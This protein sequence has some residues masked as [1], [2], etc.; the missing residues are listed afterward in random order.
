MTEGPEIPAG[1]VP[2]GDFASQHGIDEDAVVAGIKDGDYVGRVVDG[3]WYVAAE[4]APVPQVGGAHV[5]H[6]YADQEG[7]DGVI[8]C[9]ALHDLSDQVTALQKAASLV[10]SK[11]KLVVAHP[12]GAS[13]VLRQSAANPVLVKRGLPTADELRKFPLPHGIA[14]DACESGKQRNLRLWQ[15][16]Q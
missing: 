7:F 6:D 12:Q 14:T 8:F 1:M 10:R 9:S 16:Q 3:N 4:A 11:G 13:H 2:V 5:N 15:Q